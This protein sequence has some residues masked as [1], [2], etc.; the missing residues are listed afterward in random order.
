MTAHPAVTEDAPMRASRRRARRIRV[1][2]APWPIPA[3]VDRMFVTHV[4]WR[5][6]TYAMADTY[7][8]WCV[9]PADE[10]AMRFAS[11]IAAVDQ[12]E[13]AAGV[14]AASIMELERW[15]PDPDPASG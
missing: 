6:T 2:T 8:R 11:Y 15:L 4:E 13:T 10:R 1:D 14:Y 7:G 5:E 12:E 9:A 3:L